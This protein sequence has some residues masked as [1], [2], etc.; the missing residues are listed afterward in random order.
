MVAFD[1]LINKFHPNAY[2][3]FPRGCNRI[4]GIVTC[5][6][7]AYIRCIE[8]FNGRFSQRDVDVYRLDNLTDRVR[9]IV[10]IFKL[11]RWITTQLLPIEAFHLVP[12]VRT[13]TRYGHHVTW[14]DNGIMKEWNHR[15]IGRIPMDTIRQIYALNLP[16]VEHGVTNHKSITITRIGDQ[17]RSAIRTRD[18]DK[19]TV[20]NEVVM[21]V[22]QLHANGIAHCD[23]C[24]DNVFVDEKNVVFLGDLEYCQLMDLPSPRDIRRA[25]VRA[26]TG[27]ELDNIQLQHFRDELAVL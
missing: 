6:N 4:P 14:I 1:E 26:S 20:F 10:D 15:S 24:V 18:L 5:R 27:E 11:C 22:Q 8:F 17:L 2:R 7:R 25:D 21:A 19:V 3:L 13:R 16:N 12:G 9:I 23:I